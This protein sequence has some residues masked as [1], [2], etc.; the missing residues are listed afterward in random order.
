ML[1]FV[2]ISYKTSIFKCSYMCYTYL[3]Y[4]DTSISIYEDLIAFINDAIFMVEFTILLYSG[5]I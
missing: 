1:H 3:N 2:S 5:I 4:C